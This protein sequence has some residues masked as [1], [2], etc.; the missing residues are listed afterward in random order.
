MPTEIADWNDL[1]AVRNDASGDYVLVNHLDENTA[2]YDTH[3]LN[4]DEGWTPLPQPDEISFQGTFD[5]QGFEIQDLIIDSD[6]SP[7]GL[8]GRNGGTIENLGVTNVDI[9]TTNQT[10]GALCGINTGQILS[11]YTTGVVSAGESESFVGGLSATN[12]PGATIESCYSLCNTLE[13]DNEI[14]GLV[15]YEFSETGEDGVNRC[16]SAVETVV[17]D[18]E[19]VGAFCGRLGTG[20]KSVEPGYIFDSYVD[21]ELSN[22]SDAIGREPDVGEDDVEEKQTAEMQGDSP[23]TEMEEFDYDNVWE[24]VSESDGDATADGYPILRS[25]DRQKQLEAQGIFQELQ[26]PEPPS[27]LTAELL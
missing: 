14:G 1:D 2:G 27:N 13:A 23:L 26:P 11:S 4:P 9:S 25:L 10:V 5:G 3:V 24:T 17:G 20:G 7:V 21:I 16:Y 15:G 12:D 22:L 19:G 6:D 18:G 8:F